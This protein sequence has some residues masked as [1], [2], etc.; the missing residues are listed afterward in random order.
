[1]SYRGSTWTASDR[2]LAALIHGEVVAVNP[3]DD[4]ESLVKSF[5]I[6]Q[7]ANLCDEVSEA[8]NT[9]DCQQ[10]YQF[11]LFFWQK[12]ADESADV[13]ALLKAAREL[14]YALVIRLMDEHSSWETV[15]YRPIKD[16]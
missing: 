1:M 9:S 6:I 10:R 4:L 5:I 16:N 3:A 13:R 14:D 7:D 11:W 12:L 8:P 15:K 2:I